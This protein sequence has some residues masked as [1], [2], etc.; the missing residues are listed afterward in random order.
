MRRWDS[1]SA[2]G[3]DAAAEASL[4]AALRLR[5]DL[6]GAMVGLAGLLQRQSRLDESAQLYVRAMSAPAANEGFNWEACSRSGASRSRRATR[7]RVH[8]R[9]TPKLRAAL[10]LHLTLPML[11]D[12]AAHIAE[13]RAAYAD[14]LTAL[15]GLIESCTHDRSPSEVLESWQWSNFL[16]PYQ[17]HDDKALQ[18][19]YAALIARSIDIA[20][21]DLR[22]RCRGRWSVAV[23]SGSASLRRSSRSGRSAC[24]SGAGSPGSIDRNSRSSPITC[25][26]ASTPWAAR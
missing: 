25:I 4:R 22:R 15:E 12:S 6:R 13:A 5:P 17:G 8:S 1:S 21:P 23:A 7:L 3:D 19:R 20:A 18:Q 11:Y 26:R 14:G 16:L 10:G 24:I 2:T 9:R